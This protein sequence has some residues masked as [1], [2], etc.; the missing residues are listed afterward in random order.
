MVDYVDRPAPQTALSAE[1]TRQVPSERAIPHVQPD[2]LA[3]IE[4]WMSL[5]TLPGRSLDAGVNRNVDVPGRCPWTLTLG[6]QQ[7]SM[8]LR[9]IAILA[10]GLTWLL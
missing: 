3:S 2:P 8:V 6:Y 9:D 4:K 7:P 5:D 1:G 10:P